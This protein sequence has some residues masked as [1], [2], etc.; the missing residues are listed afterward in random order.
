MAA[1]VGLG[2]LGTA[3]DGL[4]PNPGGGA[5][6]CA[7]NV[8]S[9][10]RRRRR[11]EDFVAAKV[12]ITAAVVVAQLVLRGDHFPVTWRVK[13]RTKNERD[14]AVCHAVVCMVLLNTQST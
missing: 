13:R 2:S 11:G 6:L 10:R 7:L 5:G 1:T 14:S 9:S 3:S 4:P 12:A 8:R